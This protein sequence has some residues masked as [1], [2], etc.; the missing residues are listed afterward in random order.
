VNPADQVNAQASLFSRENF[1]NAKRNP[2]PQIQELCIA[3]TQGQSIPIEL[4][5]P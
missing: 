5:I 4:S 1:D 3:K 2:Q